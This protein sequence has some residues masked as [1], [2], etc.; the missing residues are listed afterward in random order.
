[1]VW[2]KLVVLPKI[3][4]QTGLCADQPEDTCF[5]KRTPSANLQLDDQPRGKAHANLMWRL[6]IVLYEK[7]AIARRI[8]HRMID[9][10]LSHNAEAVLSKVFDRRY[11]AAQ[12]LRPYFFAADCHQLRSQPFA[13]NGSMLIKPR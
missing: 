13:D 11:R 5:G 7:P 4:R 12:S 10:A 6:V 1:M 2:W 3:V 9:V 8:L